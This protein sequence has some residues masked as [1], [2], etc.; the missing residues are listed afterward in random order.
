MERWRL[1]HTFEA[2]AAL[3]MGLDQALLRNEAADARPVL[4]LYTWSPGTLSLGYFQ[5]HARI[6]AAVAALA[7]GT[8]PILRRSTGGG[9]IHHQDELTFSIVAPQEHALYRGPVAESY[10]RV[11][12]LLIEALA[13]F[14]VEAHLRG[15]APLRSDREG[16]G[17]CFHDSTSLDIAW[18]GRKGVGSAQRR[19]A[20]RV[21]HHGSIKLGTTPLEG[22]IATV[23]E[24]CPGVTAADVAAEIT[25]VAALRWSAE[26]EPEPPTRGELARAETH[27]ARHLAPDFVRRR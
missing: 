9:A 27:G 2:S 20:G 24:A 25:H 21:L 15:A 4:R 17:M 6:P 8:P 18:S 23:R 10:V 5:R 12:E 1:V 26:F 14:G 3:A 19:T 16:D 13:A 7:S 22:E 11:H